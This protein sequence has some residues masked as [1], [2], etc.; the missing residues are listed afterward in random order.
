MRVSVKAAWR[1]APWVT[2]KAHLCTAISSVTTPCRR[3]G[4]RA[5]KT[6]LAQDASLHIGAPTGQFCCR[7]GHG[8][9]LN[10]GPIQL[11]SVGPWLAES[12]SA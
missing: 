11:Q 9:N 6:H 7:S 2:A 12:T 8:F 1:L 5:K 10:D 4:K 3:G